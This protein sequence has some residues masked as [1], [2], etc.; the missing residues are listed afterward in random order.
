MSLKF[1]SEELL[2]IGRR[3][4]DTRLAKRMTQEEVAAYCDCT[5]KHISDIER[6]IVGPSFPVIAKWVDCSIQ[7][8][9]LSV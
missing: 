2:E 8:G 6:G 7:C 3:V 5:A 4:Q 9:L 1:S